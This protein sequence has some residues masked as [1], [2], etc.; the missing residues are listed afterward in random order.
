[1]LAK[2]NFLVQNVNNSNRCECNHKQMRLIPGYDFSWNNLWSESPGENAF[3]IEAKMDFYF[4]PI[5]S[6]V[7]TI[8]PQGHLW[9]PGLINGLSFQSSFFTL[10]TWDED[11]GGRSSHKRSTMTS[12]TKAIMRPF[13]IRLSS[14]KGWKT[15]RTG[16]EH[17]QVFLQRS[18]G[19]EEHFLEF[20][21]QLHCS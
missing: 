1:M 6:V 13:L 4:K 15:L 17:L 14:S 2:C 20:H 16:M 5:N 10:S 8:K 3:I 19:T 21:H 18:E 11:K 9:L 12:L 7:H